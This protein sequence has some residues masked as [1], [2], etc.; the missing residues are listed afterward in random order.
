MMPLIDEQ[1]QEAGYELWIET[2]RGFLRLEVN[3]EVA[4]SLNH[5]ITK[6]PAI[7]HPCRVSI[8]KK[9][10]LMEDKGST[11]KRYFSKVHYWIMKEDNDLILL[12]SYN[13]PKCNYK[14]EKAEVEFQK[15]RKQDSLQARASCSK[16]TWPIFRIS[17]KEVENE[18]K[19]QE[20]STKKNN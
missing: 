9:N 6:T 1:D 11:P 7:V 14:E 10:L 16:C 12:I 17:E 18:L 19:K 8:N 4:E 13:C 2:N 5:N 3:E 20:E 15:Y